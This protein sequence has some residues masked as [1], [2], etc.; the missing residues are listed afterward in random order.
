VGYWTAVGDPRSSYRK[1]RLKFRLEGE[2]LRG[3]WNLVRM[4]RPLKTGKESWLLIKEQDEEA[5]ADKQSEVT[6][7]LITSVASGRTLEEIASDRSR[8]WQSNRSATTKRQSVPPASAIDMK[9]LAGARGAP[10][11]DAILPQLATLVD[12]APVGDDWVHEVKYDGYRI[13]SRV[14]NQSATLVTRNNHDWTPKLQRIADAVAALPVKHAWL[15]GEVV[16]LLPEGTISFQALQN[17]FDMRSQAN[18]TYYVFDLLYL[19]GYDLRQVPLV[20]RKKALAAILQSHASGLLQYSDHILGSGE[21]VFEQACHQGMEG[22][23]SKRAHGA[24]VT[25][26]NRHWVKVKCGHRQEFVIGG[27]SEPAGSRMRCAGAI[28]LCGKNGNGIF[29][30]LPEG[31][32]Q[33]VD[34]ARTG[35]VTICEF[36]HG[37]RRTRCALGEAPLGDGSG[38]CRM[39]DGGIAQAGRVSGTT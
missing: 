19:D 26:R 21:V 13:L 3:I 18:L 33:E 25:G 6:Q 15:D 1:G 30:P 34:A 36:S 28:A 4:G 22:I 12:K 37:D 16:A 23:V 35:S 32:A 17:A 31:I 24:Y 10:Q 27:F 29:C 14:K 39:D 7:T 5:R 9:S 20:N 8:V 38:L 2:K 11:E